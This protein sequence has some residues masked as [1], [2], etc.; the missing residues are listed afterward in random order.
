MSSHL[1]PAESLASDLPRGYRQPVGPYRGIVTTQGPH[2]TFDLHHRRFLVWWLPSRLPAWQ[3]HLAGYHRVASPRS[4]QRHC[5]CFDYHNVIIVVTSITT[6]EDLWHC[7]DLV[8]SDI[9][10]TLRR[11]ILSMHSIVL[12]FDYA[13]P[14]S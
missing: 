7:P 3:L 4:P 10:D 13:I 5:G 11:L 9:S 2:H 14:L 8:V 1:V 12:L 6:E